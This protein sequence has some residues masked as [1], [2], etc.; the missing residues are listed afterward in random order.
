MARIVICTYPQTSF[1]D[2]ILSGPTILIYKSAQWEPYDNMK[3]AYNLLK[4]NNII[5]E[6]PIIAAKHVNKIWNDTYS[7]WNTSKVKYAR[8]YFLN[9]FNIPKN[10]KISHTYKLSKF[11]Q[12]FFDK[13]QPS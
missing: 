5:F 12:E 10:S 13:S 9:K 4:K 7:W 1:I 6:D 11:F 3:K 8:N 2:S